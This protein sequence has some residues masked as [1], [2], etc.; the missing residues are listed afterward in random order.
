MFGI[1]AIRVS[2]TISCIIW[3]I[4]LGFPQCQKKKKDVKLALYVVFT[5][6]YATKLLILNRW[7][8]KR[9]RK[10]NAMKCKC[11][12]FSRSQ[13]CVVCST[14]FFIYWP[15]RLAQLLR[16]MYGGREPSWCS[17]MAHENGRWKLTKI[18]GIR[19]AIKARSF[20]S[21]RR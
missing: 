4:N 21:W 12:N 2:L 17:N 11:I 9:P 1:R 7:M 8:K 13:V 16:A 15:K 14:L 6:T 20:H 19:F 5:V 10:R 3:K 18:I